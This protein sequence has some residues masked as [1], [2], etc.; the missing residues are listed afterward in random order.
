ME[1]INPQAERYC[2][3]W[4]TSLSPLLHRIEE[5]TYA[6]HAQPHMLSGPLQGK[7]L[8]MICSMIQPM[9]VLEIGTFTGYSAL[10]MMEGMPTK[11]ELHTIE[12]RE[13]DA[14]LAQT[15][16]NESPYAPRIHMHPGDARIIIPQLDKTWDLVFLDADKVSYI[17]Y[18]ELT[19]PSIRKGGWILADNVLFHGQVLAEVITGKNAKAV[20]AFNQHVAKDDRVRQ[21]MLTIRDG[22]MLIQKK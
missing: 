15:Y 19:L 13:D 16:F 8:E 18:Y 1:I 21:V 5:E 14:A 22:L 3:D 10:A 4:S 2:V 12:I 9:N 11:A 7:F 20:D 6:S 17:D